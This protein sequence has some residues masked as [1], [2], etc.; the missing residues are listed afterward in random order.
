[1]FVR[2][3]GR[4]INLAHVALAEDHALTPP[5]EPPPRDGLAPGGMRLFFACQVV[6]D[7]PAPDADRLRR[8]FRELDPEPLPGEVSQSPSDKGWRDATDQAKVRERHPKGRRRRKR[9]GE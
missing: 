7:V 2:L 6:R 5:D 1:M 9:E 3:A 4:L 8:R